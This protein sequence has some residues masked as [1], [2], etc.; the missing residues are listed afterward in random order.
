MLRRFAPFLVLLAILV[1]LLASQAAAPRPTTADP[2]VLVDQLRQCGGSAGPSFCVGLPVS[3]PTVDRAE[4]LVRRQDACAQIDAKEAPDFCLVV[5]AG[6]ASTAALQR[7]LALTILRQRLGA[8]FRRTTAGGV[9][10]WTEVGVSG[11]IVDVAL[12]LVGADAAAVQEYFGRSYPEP[13]AV[14]LFTS[15]QSFSL[16]LQKFFGVE[17]G[18]AARLSQQL[19]GVL[20]KGSDAVA[21][22][23]ESIVTSGRPVVYRHELA[24]VLIHQ[25]SGD[26]IP[27]WLDEGLATRV[28]AIDP[29][30]IDP[31]RAA[32]I[33]SLKTDRRA[34]SIFTDRRDWQTVNTAF[35]NG[36]YG[37]AAEAVLQIERRA[38]RDGVV[39]LLEGIGRGA[40][41]EEVFR[42]V[43][44]ETLD[45]FIARLPLVVRPDLSVI[46]R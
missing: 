15:H 39:A 30:V 42:A 5:P 29:A 33:A 23:G 19:L 44:G 24:H 8:D 18:V 43:M 34:L 36:A 2:M 4:L 46:G 10:L 11:P 1:A 32:A 20:L 40:S 38:G 21:I 45:D 3:A 6:G 25:I 14:F 22:N 31:A 9:Q 7:D 26:G 37:V 41:L 35:A 27:A 16:A 28:S 12:R 13:P 17:P